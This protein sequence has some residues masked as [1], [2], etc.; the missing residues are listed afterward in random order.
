M[1]AMNLKTS[2][3]EKIKPTSFDAEAIEFWDERARIQLSYMDAITAY[4][5]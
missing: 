1:K 4:L 3:F 2:S 5:D